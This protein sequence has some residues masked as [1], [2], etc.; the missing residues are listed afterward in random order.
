[1]P[2]KP[3]EV[4]HKSGEPPLCPVS[5]P[6]MVPRG[7]KKLVPRLRSINTECRREQHAETRAP[8]M[9]V[10]NHAH[11]VSGMRSCHA[12]GAHVGVVVMKFSAPTRADAENRDADNHKSAPTSPGPADCRA[13]S[14]AYRSNHA[15]GAPPATKEG[16]NHNDEAEEVVQN[17]SMFKTG[18]AMSGAPI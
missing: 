5:W 14:G 3:E 17:E 12:L 4:L 2:K 6:L 10:T 18:K 11:T 7:T 9:A 1:M 13:L 15:R 8:R 16:R